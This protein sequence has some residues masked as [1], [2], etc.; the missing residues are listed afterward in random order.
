MTDRAVERSSQPKTDASSRR[1][2]FVAPH[3]ATMYS[4]GRYHAWIMAEAIAAGGADVIVWTTERPFL[5]RDFETYPSHGRIGLHIDPDFSTRPSGTFTA[6]VL[7]PHLRMDWGPYMAA[8]SAAR[9]LNAPMVFL[10]FEA[11]AWFNAENAQQRSIF[12]T[13]A[14]WA[15]ARYADVILS[16][17]AYSSERAREY[18]RPYRPSLAFR[19]CYPSINSIAA[20]SVK[21]DRVKQIICISRLNKGNQHK[22]IAEL[23]DVFSDHITGYS[24]VVIGTMPQ[25]TEAQLRRAA[26]AHGVKF[27]LKSGLTDREKFEEIKKSRLMV[28]LSTFEGFGYPPLEALYC[29]TPC[30]VNPL[31]VLREVS[32][33]ALIYLNGAA[34]NLTQTIQDALERK[35]PFVPPRDRER[36]SQTV[37]FE[38]YVARLDHLF[39]DLEKPEHRPVAACARGAADF[40]AFMLV[41]N[42]FKWVYRAVRPKAYAPH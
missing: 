19:Y 12:R 22:G 34:P 36:I 9:N 40:G 30:I 16:S 8:V 14:F 39:A 41:G 17:T 31:P 6:V 2:L 24:M 42:F 38:S 35:E 28:F 23:L 10:D 3:H 27:I 4:G 7:A 5:I 11:P 33:D 13:A 37:R 26:D 32:G 25:E 18:Y 21:A 20:D 15:S 1:V 29:G